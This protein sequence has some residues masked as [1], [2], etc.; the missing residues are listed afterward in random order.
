MAAS[1]RVLYEQGVERA[2]IADIARAAD[3]PV[4]NVYYYFKTK[5]ELVEGALRE[6]AKQL[7]VMTGRLDE[8]P[9]PRERLRGLIGVWIDQRDI[10]ARYGC[11]VTNI[12]VEIDKRDV[13][14]PSLA[15]RGVIQQ[16]LDWAEL[17]YRQMGVSDPAGRALALIGAYQ[18]VTVISNS[19]RDPDLIA[20]EA[21][22]LLRELDALT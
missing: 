19:L 15:V 1:A 21:A 22:R 20:R 3:V 9:D 11:P 7:G 13:G 6:I 17:Q 2:T 10:M 16:L 5:D 4:G 8:L 12:A 14:G 18:G